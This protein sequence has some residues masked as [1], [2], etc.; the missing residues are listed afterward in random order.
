MSKK[1]PPVASAER[2]AVLRFLLGELPEALSQV[3]DDAIP[4]HDAPWSDRLE[5]REVFVNLHR[6]DVALFDKPSGRA[7][8]YLDVE[9][10]EQKTAA[11]MAKTCNGLLEY[12]DSFIPEEE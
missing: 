5:F 6:S 10:G 1:S 9:G 7:L 11:A 4:R 2:V 3:L 8:F 12:L